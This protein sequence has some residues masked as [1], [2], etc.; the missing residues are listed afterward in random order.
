M[1]KRYGPI[2][3]YHL[4]KNDDVFYLISYGL[5][6][7]KDVYTWNELYFFKDKYPT[8][9]IDLIKSSVIDD[10]NKETDNKILN[11]FKWN[12]LPVYLSSEN[13]FN[14]IKLLMI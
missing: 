11:E 4:Y 10:I 6:E 3:Y 7:Y 2:E 9:N 8:I 12:D 1:S 5:T 13:Q 14:F